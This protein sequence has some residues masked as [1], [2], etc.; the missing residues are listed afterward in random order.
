MPPDV[1]TLAYPGEPPPVASSG[2]RGPLSQ[3]FGDPGWHPGRHLDY[4]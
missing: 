2:R 1:P 4:D 3:K